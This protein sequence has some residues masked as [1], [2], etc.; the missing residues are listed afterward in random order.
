MAG[1][2]PMAGTVTLGKS[3]NCSQRVSASLKD[4]VSQRLGV[5]DDCWLWGV[6]T[7]SEGESELSAR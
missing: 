1:L 4:W 7:V 2:V 6:G 3:V 5:G